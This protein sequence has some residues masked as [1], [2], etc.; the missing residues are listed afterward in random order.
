MTYQ[1][2]YVCKGDVCYGSPAYNTI[3]ECKKVI[4]KHKEAHKDCNILKV[5]IV[6]RDGRQVSMRE[7]TE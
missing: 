5:Y 1:A 7:Y 6:S 2:L 3:A 4:P